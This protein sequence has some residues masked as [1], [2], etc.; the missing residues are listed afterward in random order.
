MNKEI[1]IDMEQ[2][3]SDLIDSGDSAT[4]IEKVIKEMGREL[5]QLYGF[6]SVR[7][8]YNIL[9]TI[10]KSYILSDLEKGTEEYEVA[11]NVVLRKLKMLHKKSKSTRKRSSKK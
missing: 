9:I 10:L 6:S 8:S 1:Y 2:R 4:E 3:F 11:T 7:E 5:K